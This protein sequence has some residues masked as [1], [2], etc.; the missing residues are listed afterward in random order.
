MSNELFID[1]DDIDRVVASIANPE[2]Y[3]VGEGKKFKTKDDALRGKI[4]SDLYVD[5]LTI[6][7]NEIKARAE[8]LQAELDKLRDDG[9]DALAVIDRVVQPN[10]ND[11]NPQAKMMT[12]EEI[13]ARVEQVLNRKRDIESRKTNVDRVKESLQQTWGDAWQ[14]KLKEAAKEYGGEEQLSRLIETN[15]KAALKL[16]GSPEV[17]STPSS[18]PLFS[19]PTNNVSVGHRSSSE[20]IR[21]AKYFNELRKKDPASYFKGAAFTERMEAMARLGDDYHKH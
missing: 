1:Q 19:P 18:N 9:K 7:K 21:G 20:P 3:L 14:D 8:A 4:Y 11:G 6:E 16:V 5:K 15:P 2:D 13:E 12:E 17:K 10:P